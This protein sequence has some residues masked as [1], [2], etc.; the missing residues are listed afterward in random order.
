MKQYKCLLNISSKLYIFEMLNYKVPLDS[1]I[2]STGTGNTIH[3][4]FV[5]LFKITFEILASNSLISLFCFR[6]TIFSSF[7]I[8]YIKVYNHYIVQPFFW[9]NHLTILADHNRSAYHP[10]YTTLSVPSCNV[11]CIHLKI[12]KLVY[13]L[14][15]FD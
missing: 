6:H 15:R 12:Q 14:L 8:N 7:I 1:E 2:L 9:I 5:L 4:F 11:E 10:L 3:R 13:H